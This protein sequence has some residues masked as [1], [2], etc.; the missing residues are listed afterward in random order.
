MFLEIDL[1]VNLCFFVGFGSDEPQVHHTLQT[2]LDEYTDEL[3]YTKQE[4]LETHS[5]PIV[6]VFD[7][8]PTFHQQQ[9]VNTYA[10]H[11]KNHPQDG[12][13][14][15]IRNPDREKNLT[16]DELWERIYERVART[17]IVEA[18]KTSIQSMNASFTSVLPFSEVILH[19]VI[20]TL[21]GSFKGDSGYHTATPT[22]LDSISD[23]FWA[24]RENQGPYSALAASLSK[25]NG[26]LAKEYDPI[27]P[28]YS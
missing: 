11:H 21:E 1:E 28:A 13:K 14:L 20:S 2:V 15:I 10:L 6:A 7:A 8:Y 24:A 17:L 19:Q 22:W 26:R 25:L 18:L 9:I 27:N 5:A 12:D 23:V 3:E 16:A 4:V